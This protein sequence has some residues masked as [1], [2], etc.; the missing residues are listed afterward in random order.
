MDDETKG[1]VRRCAKH[2]VNYNAEQGNCALC[3]F[4]GR[5]GVLGAPERRGGT[6]TPMR[7]T[8]PFCGSRTVYEKSCSRY[9]C[10]SRAGLQFNGLPKPV[11]RTC[12]V[13]GGR[14]RNRTYCTKYDCRKIAGTV[15]I[16]ERRR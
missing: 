12:V 8:C 14:T 4:D 9:Q 5:P 11:M 1:R 6:G 15:S 2:R 7:F 10:R 13:C 16:Y 3:E